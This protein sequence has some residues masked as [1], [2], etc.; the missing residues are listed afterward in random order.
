M[1]IIISGII[2]IIITKYNNN[3]TNINKLNSKITCL[4][5]ISFQKNE[6]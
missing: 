2:I 4:K 5:M 6:Y 1:S 3:D